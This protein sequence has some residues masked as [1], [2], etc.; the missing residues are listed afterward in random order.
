MDQSFL[1]RSVHDH[2]FQ[3]EPHGQ[4]VY[5][6]LQWSSVGSLESRDQTQKLEGR[7]P[8]SAGFRAASTLRRRQDKHQRLQWLFDCGHQQTAKFRYCRGPPCTWGCLA[9]RLEGFAKIVGTPRQ[10]RK[11]LHVAE[12]AQL[13]RLFW[14]YRTSIKLSDCALQK[15]HA[16]NTQVSKMMEIHVYAP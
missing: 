11:P 6:P 12:V 14:R 7:S 13:P 5:N 2:R 4:R 9:M 1:C 8:H 3:T 16:P 15:H 10:S